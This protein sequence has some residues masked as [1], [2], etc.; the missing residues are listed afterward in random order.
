M[1]ITVFFSWQA[2]HPNREGRGLIEWALNRAIKKIRSDV[3]IEPAAREAQIDHDTQGVSGSPPIV[4]TIFQKIDKATVF[5][6]D[7]TFV[8]RRVGGRP[9]PN[10]NVLIEYGYALKSLKHARIV[11]VMNVAHGEPTWDAMPFNMRHL[12]NPNA[13]YNCP[14]DLGNDERNRVR[15]DLA[16]KLER[17]L[18]AVFESDD[19]KEG[20]P[21]PPAP[22]PFIPKPSSERRGVFRKAGEPLGLLDTGFYRGATEIKLSEEPA[23]WF[24]VMPAFDPGRT[25]S[26]AE[27]DSMLKARLLD[28][29]SRG[30]PGYSLVRG[31]DGSG[32]YA[33]IREPNVARAV[34]YVFTTGEIWAADTF[35]LTPRD[36]GHRVIPNDVERS[37]RQSLV[38]FGDF[39]LNQ[40]K[41][42]APYRWI[43]GM[44]DLRGRELYIPPRPGYVS[45]MFGPQG[46]GMIDFIEKSGRYSP[47]DSPAEVLRP[48]FDALYEA[49]GATRQPW[50]DEK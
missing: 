35:F 16:T 2:D 27:I 37:F 50:Q 41:I 10:P 22:S 45:H 24:R 9:T 30:W 46:K 12:R 28:P 32:V 17:A 39:L 44:D 7:L 42:S 29:L 1:S 26:V 15:Q 8:G 19:F 36:D 48:F 25:W 18:R 6:P 5:V 31:P 33:S 14:T 11:P 47:D 34:A 38:Q 23:V 13:T 3:E 40:L 49:C 43:A 20:L 4:D 21:K